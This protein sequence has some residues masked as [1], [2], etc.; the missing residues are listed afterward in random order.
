MDVSLLHLTVMCQ[1]L[2]AVAGLKVTLAATEK[3]K[4]DLEA[5]A[6][7]TTDQLK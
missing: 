7:N 3:K 4:A 2:A 1:I 6:K 5:E